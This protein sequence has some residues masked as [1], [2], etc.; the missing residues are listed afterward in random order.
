MGLPDRCNCNRWQQHV[1]ADTV[2]HN[3]LTYFYR[4]EFQERGTLHLH[5]LLWVKDVS[6]IQVDLLQASMPWENQND[7]FLVAD[8][9]KSNRL[10]LS[11][12]ESSC[13]SF[14]QRSDGSTQLEFRY[15]PEDAHRNIR[16]F[17]TTLQGSLHCRTNVQV[18]GWKAMLLKYVTSYVTKMHNASTS[19]GLYCS[20][21]SGFQAANSFL[22]TVRPLAP[23]MIFQ[24]SVI[25]VAWTNKMTKQFRPPYPDQAADNPAYQLYLRC[26]RQDED[27]PLLQ[28]L[29]NH[30]ICKNKIKALDRGTRTWWP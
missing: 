22:R 5:M 10:S 15:T 7:A 28:W 26:H 17:M 20:D 24:Q 14:V 13:N 6:V 27:V 21:T 29:R 4:F 25:K 19:E 9:Q 30:N 12:N 2:N 3:I 23:K 16:A 1:F 8:I 18:A 11:I